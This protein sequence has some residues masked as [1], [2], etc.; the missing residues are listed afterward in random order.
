MDRCCYSRKK[1]LA[2]KGSIFYCLNEVMSIGLRTK[3]HCVFLLHVHLV[4]VTKYRRKIFNHEHLEEMKL[5]FTR[6]CQSFES[7]LIEC[8]GET[9]HVHLLVSYPPKIPVSRLVNSLKTSTSRVLRNKYPQHIKRHLWK[10]S[11]WSPSYF[12]GSCGGAPLELVKNYIESQR[13]S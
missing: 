11:L 13:E 6:V 1:Y 3:R 4:F 5:I 12:A 8:D 7:E 2:S 10:D 9:D